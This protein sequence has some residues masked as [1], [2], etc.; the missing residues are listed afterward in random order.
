MFIYKLA[1]AKQLHKIDSR[2]LF[3]QHKF[4]VGKTNVFLYKTFEATEL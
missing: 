2:L 3:Y 4:M 1:F